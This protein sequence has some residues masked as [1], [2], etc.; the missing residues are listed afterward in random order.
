ME[1]RPFIIFIKN[2]EDIFS[3]INNF[4]Y[5]YD[6]VISSYPMRVYFIASSS[7]NVYTLPRVVTDKFKF[8]QCVKPVEKKYRGEYIKFISNKIGIDIHMND[9]ELNEFA[10]E[11][12]DSFSNRDIFNMITN[13]IEIKKKKSPP[14]DEN[15]VYR[16]GLNYNDIMNGMNT[17]K[18]TITP[19]VKKMYFL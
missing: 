2:M 13:A 11:S 15:W 10:E 19:D 17:I 16:E 4:N 9:N 6:K 1:G 7:I 18:G 12:L 5:I 3:T 14:N 8:F